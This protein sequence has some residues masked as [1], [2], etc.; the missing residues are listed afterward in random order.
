MEERSVLYEHEFGDKKMNIF[1]TLINSLKKSESVQIFRLGKAQ[2]R[3]L[4]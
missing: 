3:V 1:P 4:Q 2:R